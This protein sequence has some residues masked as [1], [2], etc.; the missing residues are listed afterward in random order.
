MR[1]VNGELLKDWLTD[2]GRSGKHRLAEE[3]EISKGFLYRIIR[4]DYVP[5]R[6]DVRRRIAKV[7]GVPEDE[8][9]PPVD[10]RR[11]A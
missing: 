5:K 6:W 3:A 2:N 9:F 7:V 8:L 1:T 10:E 11:E 4:D